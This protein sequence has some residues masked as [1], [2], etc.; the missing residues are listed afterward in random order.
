MADDEI[1]IKITV[2]DSELEAVKRDLGTDTGSGEESK[3]IDEITGNQGKDTML[4]EAKAHG[5]IGASMGGFKGIGGAGK[6]LGMAKGMASNPMGAMAGMMQNMGF[7]KNFAKM[8]PHVALVIMAV[9]I[10]PMVIKQIIEQLTKA[11][12]PFDKRFKRI[13]AKERNAFFNREEQRKRQLGLSPVI[14]TTVSGFR[15]IGG[16]GSTWTLKEVREQNGIAPIGLRDKAGG[17]NY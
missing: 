14:M 15:N 4:D 5:L 2:D 8:I 9:E 16:Y 11:G 10:I 17:V 1:V 12:S 7:V 13:M 3:V 6:G